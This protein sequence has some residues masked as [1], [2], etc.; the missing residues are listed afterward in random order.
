MRRWGF[1]L[2]AAALISLA[3]CSPN[4]EDA[5]VMDPAAPAEEADHSVS[6]LNQAIQAG[7]ENLEWLEEVEGEDALGFARLQNERSLGLL[8]SDP[9]Y[10]TLYDQAI[11]VLESTDRIPYVAVRNG[12]LWN[13]WRDAQNIHGLWRKTSVDSYAT[14]APEWDVVLDL[15]ALADAEETNW[16]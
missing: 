10:Q 8:Q 12:E 11:E 16:V 5:D 15:D 9:R 4:S 7:E 6:A 13:F 1:S 2:T 14:G 3:A